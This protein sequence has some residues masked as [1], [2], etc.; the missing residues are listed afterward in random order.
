MPRLSR[1]SDKARTGHKCTTVIGVR[2]TQFEVFANNK[3][4]A[5]RGDPTKGHT[6]LAPND[7]PR[8]IGHKAKINRGSR[9]VFAKGIPVARVGDSTDKGRMIQGSRTVHAG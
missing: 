8:C 4:V 7:P 3:P 1:M 6:I 5:R 9:T 2:A